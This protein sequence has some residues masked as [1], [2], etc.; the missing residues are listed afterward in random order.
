[1]FIKGDR[2]TITL[3]PTQAKRKKSVI[4]KTLKNNKQYNNRR[5]TLVEYQKIYE[6]IIKTNQKDIELPRNPNVMTSIT[7]GGNN[8]I[9]LRKDTLTKKLYSYGISKE[10]HGKLYESIELILKAAKLN[11]QEVN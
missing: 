2:L 4:V 7:D 11:I 10:Y 1:M 5:I 9:I 8:S 3:L 6:L